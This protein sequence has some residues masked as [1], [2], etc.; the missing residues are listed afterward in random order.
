MEKHKC[1]LICVNESYIDSD[2][3]SGKL[4]EW[5]IMSIAQYYVENLARESLR[6]LKV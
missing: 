5:I 1:E 6:G 2:S 3:T 4:S